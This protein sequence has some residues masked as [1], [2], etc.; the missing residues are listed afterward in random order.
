VASATLLLWAFTAGVASG[1][2]ERPAWWGGWRDRRALG[3]IALGT[4]TG[5]ICGVWLSQVATKHAPVG[6]A[7]TLMALVPLFVLAED[8][9]IRRRRPHARELLGSTIAIAGV[10]L[11]MMGSSRA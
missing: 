8:A 1:R 2:R 4:V 11:L 9:V 5:P 6:V 10:V 7:A 3:L